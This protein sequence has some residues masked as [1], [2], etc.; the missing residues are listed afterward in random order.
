MRLRVD[1]NPECDYPFDRNFLGKSNYVEGGLIMRLR[2]PACDSIRTKKNGHIHNGKQNRRCKK[3]GRQFVENPRQKLISVEKREQIRNL[4]LERIPL[5]GIC[6]AMGVSL[7]WLLGFIASEYEQLPDDLN[8][9]ASVE[10]DKLLIWSIDVSVNLK[11]D[12]YGGVRIPENGREK[13]LPQ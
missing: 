12:N 4:L 9:R 11:M 10:T 2:C 3:C 13:S 8:Y 1:K 5:R 6:R 7:G